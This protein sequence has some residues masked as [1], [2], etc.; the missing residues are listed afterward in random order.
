MSRH[1]RNRQR[2]GDLSPALV[3]CAVVVDSR[4]L[5]GQSGRLFGTPSN[6]TI[7]GIRRALEAYG[8]DPVEVRVGTA[9]RV[10]QEKCSERVNR[11][12]QKNE[13]AAQG[14]EA[15]GATILHGYLVERGGTVEEKQVD[16]L[17]AVAIADLAERILVKASAA[18]C[19]VSLSEDMDLMPE[20]DFAHARDVPVFA[21]AIDTV[22]VRTEQRAWMLLDEEAI[23]LSCPSSSRYRGMRL[24]AW[25]ARIALESVQ[26]AGVWTVGFRLADGTYEM[27]RNN[28]ARGI[29]SNPDGARSGQKVTLYATGVV[30]DATTRR[31][32]YLSL[33]DTASEGPF[34]NVRTGTVQFWVAQN[35][36]KVT[37]DSGDNVTVWAPAGSLLPGQEV[38]VL[39]GSDDSC[40][41]IGALDK[42]EEPDLWTVAPR[43]RALVEVTVGQ[44][45]KG[46]AKGRLE[47]SGQ[48]VAIALKCVTLR[49]R[50]RLAVSLVGTHP[51]WGIPAVHPMMSPLPELTTTSLVPRVGDL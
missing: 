48:E 1:G 18:Q 9:T 12:R 45:T 44:A 46:W 3:P 10:L 31:F 16:V 37:L 24:R 7:P 25:I 11:M 2:G 32:P 47:E 26:V 19:I 39:N 6:F 50:D 14:L 5:I 36:V 15:D 40:T 41:L 28:G 42:G 29:W 27:S 13:D 20:Y 22:H 33:S 34:I 4:N 21:A 23:D 51:T 30:A 43:R 8:F 35:R 17:C 49:E 38:A